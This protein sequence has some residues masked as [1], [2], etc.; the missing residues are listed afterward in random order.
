MAYNKTTWVDGPAGGTPINA[1]N[2]QKIEDGIEALESQAVGG[3]VTK[4]VAAAGDSVA[5]FDKVF[6]DTTGGAFSLVLPA[7]PDNGDTVKFVDVKGNFATANFT[8]AVPSGVNLMGTLNDTLV[9]VV[10]YDFVDMTYF[11]A[12]NN[13]IITSKP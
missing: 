7:S 5:A 10:D 13:W 1:A 12:D 2:L 3:W 9:L 8:I 11:A 6:V 4:D